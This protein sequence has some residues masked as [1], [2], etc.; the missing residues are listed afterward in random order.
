MFE[1][2]LAIGMY[3]SLRAVI[4]EDRDGITRFTYDLPSSTLGQFDN[5]EI[6]TMARVL[7][8]RMKTLS[9]LLAS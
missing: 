7:D 8:E 1:Q 9:D 5:E 3:A 2:D 6:R 4:F